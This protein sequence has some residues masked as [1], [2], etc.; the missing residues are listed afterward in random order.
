[1]MKP[2]T[3]P[4]PP[5]IPDTV[6]DWPLRVFHWL[7]AVSVSGAVLTGWLGGNLMPWHGRLG[8]LTLGLIV[9]RL[10]WGV[11]GTPAARFSQFVPGPAAIRAYLRGAWQGMGH[12]P[13]GALSVIALLLVIGFQAVSGH[14]ARDDIAFSGPLASLIEA[15]TSSRLT[16]LHSLSANLVIGLVLLHLA[17]IV[18]HVRIK[19]EDLITPMWRGQG[20]A[21][22]QPW[23][24]G[25]LFA[26]LLS[27]ALAVATVWGFQGNWIPEPPAAA[28][29]P[30]EFDW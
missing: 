5:P 18:Y 30:A 14:F 4:S 13:L 26:V 3:M 8:A 6:W 20:P 22:R 29:A 11:L 24:R 21:V 16:S 15:Q 7:L 25:G 27:L 23:G 9:F 1:M 28:Q 12:N 19:R 10:A 17:A 2:N